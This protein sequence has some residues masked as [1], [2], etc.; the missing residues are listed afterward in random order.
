MATSPS[1]TGTETSRPLYRGLHHLENS[2][3]SVDKAVKPLDPGPD[4]NNP[5]TVVRGAGQLSQSRALGYH[6]WLPV[7]KAGGPEPS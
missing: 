7:V 3:G 2:L 1:R 6:L 4:L 5:H